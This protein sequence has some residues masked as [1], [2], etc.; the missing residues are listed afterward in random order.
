MMVHNHRQYARLLVHAITG[1][2]NLH[3][4]K[5]KVELPE[6]KYRT[7]RAKIDAVLQS[8]VFESHSYKFYSLILRFYLCNQYLMRPNL[9]SVII[10]CDKSEAIL[11]IKPSN[12][13][14]CDIGYPGPLKY[15]KPIIYQTSIA[16]TKR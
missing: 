10:S 1:S 2:L 5:A 7:I 13:V 4:T 14:K 6:Q 12:E 11:Q 9:Y 8:T 3:I 16:F 15:R